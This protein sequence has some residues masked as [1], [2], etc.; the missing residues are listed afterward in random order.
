MA[1]GESGNSQQVGVLTE[2]FGLLRGLYR[3][4]FGVFIPGAIT[5]CFF[6]ALPVLTYVAV[7]GKFEDLKRI[8][9]SGFGNVSAAG[10]GVSVV[11]SADGNLVHFFLGILFFIVAYAIGGILW[12]RPIEHA[13]AV[14]AFR[15]WCFARPENLGRLTVQFVEVNTQSLEDLINWADHLY[16]AMKTGDFRDVQGILKSLERILKKLDPKKPLEYN[17]LLPYVRN[18][19][20]IFDAVEE[21]GQEAQR[22]NTSIGTGCEGVPSLFRCLINMAFHRD[23]CGDIVSSDWVSEDVKKLSVSISKGIQGLGSHACE[24]DPRVILRKLKHWINSARADYKS[25]KKL[26][27]YEECLRSVAKQSG[28]WQHVWELFLDPFIGGGR[29][30]VIARGGGLNVT[31]PYPFL[32]C[33]LLSR[34]LRDLARFV[35]WCGFS[36]DESSIC[37][38][39]NVINLLKY[40]VRYYGD[41]D[42]VREMDRNECHIRMLNSLWYSFRFVRTMIV[43]CLL[44]VILLGLVG[45][46]ES[47]YGHLNSLEVIPDL[48][49]PYTL[50]LFCIVGAVLC[51]IVVIVRCRAIVS[52][53]AVATASLLIAL[54]VIGPAA[55]YVCWGMGGEPSVQSALR[56][57]MSAL[58][59]LGYA[60]TFCRRNIEK[61]FHYVREREIIYIL[62]AADILRKE[63]ERR[64]D[65]GGG[66]F[67]DLFNESKDS[68]KSDLTIC[69]HC[70]RRNKCYVESKV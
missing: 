37:G 64:K 34:G 7:M 50:L 44:L 51:I 27:R 6:I 68:G 19:F 23:V 12:R 43:S 14:A 30:E 45:N 61:G 38:G 22:I 66:V 65:A 69:N 32:K 49:K 21:S 25:V 29:G 17:R 35:G 53:L 41:S 57:F 33:F 31:Y 54:L 2:C 28:S 47:I 3:E 1:N 26:R 67:D 60:V 52:P 5:T 15:Q 62:S 70:I 8:I 4:V 18:L 46:W 13:D 48:L 39:K 9:L 63:G 42:M 56:W 40:R 36:T 10:A 55:A 16:G 24:S 11:T 58:V 20:S 59:V